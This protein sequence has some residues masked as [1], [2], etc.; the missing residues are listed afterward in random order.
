M[1]IVSTGDNFHEM[2]N[3]VLWEKMRKHIT[4][5]LS[6]ESAHGVVKFKF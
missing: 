1:Q 3:P 4:D 6:A 2:S 5:L